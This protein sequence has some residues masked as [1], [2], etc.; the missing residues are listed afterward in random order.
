[1]A[2]FGAAM[3]ILSGL[4]LGL[5]GTVAHAV[6]MSSGYVFFLLTRRLPSRRK[7]AFELKKKRA[8]VTTAAEN[9][10]VEK[11]NA[12]WDDRVR[13][14]EERAR[15]EGQVAE[16]DQLLLAELDGAVDEQITVCAPEDFGYVNDSVCRSCSG[17]AECAARRIRMA[18]DE[19]GGDTSEDR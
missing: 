8:E 6:G 15:S 16:A 17:Y 18:A 4:S 13:A 7:L 14:A 3:L 19:A 5:L 9:M 1:L 11:R 2:L 10:A 12:S